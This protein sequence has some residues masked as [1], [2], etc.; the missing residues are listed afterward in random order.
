[1]SDGLSERLSGADG[2]ARRGRGPGLGLVWFLVWSGWKRQRL[3]TLLTVLGAALGVAVVT[4]I[5]VID[6]N[7][8]QSRMRAQTPE[9]VG[10]DFEL[11][12]KIRELDPV[13]S[14]DRLRDFD[15]LRAAAPI[16]Q[17]ARIRVESESRGGLGFGALYGLRPG[18]DPFSRIQL[19]DGS[20]PSASELQATVGAETE[21]DGVVLVGP[22]FVEEQGVEVGDTLVLAPPPLAPRSRCINGVRVPVESPIERVLEPRRVRVAGRLRSA[23]LG[24]RDQGRV[25]VSGLEIARALAPTNPTVLQAQLAYGR[26]PDRVR[27]RLEQDFLVSDG[28]SAL[29]GE[30]ADERAFRNGLKLLGGLALMLGMFVVFQTLSQSLAERLRQIGLWKCLGVG[31]GTVGAVFLVDAVVVA[32]L[33]SMLGAG[34]G[35]VLAFALQ[36][37]ELSSLG[38]FE[39]WQLR[40]IPPGPVLWTAGLGFVFTIA[41]AFFPWWRARRL[42]AVEI[43]NARGLDKVRDVLRGVHLYLFALLCLL[44]PIGYLSMT[45]ILSDSNEEMVLVLLQLAGFLFLFG[46]ILLLAPVVVTWI[47]RVLLWPA[48]KIWSF[49]AHLANKSIYGQRGRIATSICGLSIVFLAVLGVESLTS[50]LHGDVRRLRRE[51]LHDTLY[52]YG[53]SAKT[54]DL[55]RLA[56]LDGVERVDRFLGPVAGPFELRAIDGDSLAVADRPF[57]GRS[58]LR[59]V[60]DRERS[61]VVSR[62]LALLK[63]LRVGDGLDVGTEGGS[64]RYRVLAIS[65][66]AGFFPDERAFALCSPKWL[67]LD[68]CIGDERTAYCAV[69]LKPGTNLSVIRN[70]ANEWYGFTQAKSGENI[71][72]T[73]RND[74]TRDF[75]LFQILL[76]LI[77]GL[78]ALGVVN[79]M[80]IATLGRIREL[81]VLRA[82]GTSQR[83]ILGS[84]VLE[85]AVTGL[86]SALIALGLGL[87]LGRLLVEGMNRVA[88]V[89]APYV[90]PS[91]ALVVVPILGVVVGVAAAVVPG[92]RAAR[93]D[94]AQAVRFE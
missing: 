8:I 35:L 25:L 16:H 40:E 74:V 30:S 9:A 55:D 67:K 60:F 50:A 54:V 22:W 90:L 10:I 56:A 75:R 61:V 58:D 80:T 41:G 93:I 79:A 21:L 14:L 26:D 31:S 20:W 11:T 28:T 71:Y 3:R 1:M 17:A 19:L 73:L 6:H 76:A 88:K 52:L 4:A 92:L 36:Q 59:E 70:Q 47:G 87:P 2:A 64:V 51:T 37:L 81:G 91:F 82:L 34:L 94:P 27:E 38:R 48:T 57:D 42:S 62:R 7:T 53:G 23:G 65:D 13:A 24:A 32:A 18:D 83:Q 39:E 69:R 33:G 89:D 72:R 46:A 63:D 45:T 49:P 86:L 29:L 85:G 78:A 77:L 12:P 68:F 66:R 15:S 43:L 84:L 5:H 44:L